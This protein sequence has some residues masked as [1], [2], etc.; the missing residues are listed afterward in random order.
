MKAAGRIYDQPGYRPGIS[1]GISNG[2]FKLKWRDNCYE[3]G[4]SSNQSFY[5]SSGGYDLSHPTVSYI[6]EEAAGKFQRSARIQVSEKEDLGELIYDSGEREDICSTGFELPLE[7]KPMTRYYWRVSVTDDA[8]DTGWS[9]TAWFET[10]KAVSGFDT[11][12]Q[13][14]WITPDASKE[15]QAAVFQDV[16]ITKP[17][18]KARAYMTGLGLYEFYLDGAKQGRTV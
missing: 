14:R 13:A 12:W 15:V 17:V 18:A 1:T 11:E 8:G 10:S 7:L 2:I 4:P 5:R 6:V 9:D 3:N 16:N